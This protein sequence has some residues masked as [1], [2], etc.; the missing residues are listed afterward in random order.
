MPPIWRIVLT[1]PAPV[2]VKKKLDIVHL[3]GPVSN[4]IV[5]D[6]FWTNV[7]KWEASALN[8]IVPFTFVALLKIPKSSPGVGFVPGASAV[9]FALSLNTPP[10]EEPSQMVVVALACSDN[11]EKSRAQATAR[12]PVR[13]RTM[14]R[15]VESDV[16]LPVVVISHSSDREAWA[17]PVDEP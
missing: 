10:D 12:T 5:P 16:L 11:V 17:C 4:E 8:V 6:V 14:V 1:S 15:Q 2:P 3:Y 13:W 9:Q 7:R